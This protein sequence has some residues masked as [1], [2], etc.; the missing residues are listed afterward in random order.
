MLSRA[1]L[2]VAVA[3][4]A[5]AALVSACSSS[6]GTSSSSAPSS[7]SASAAASSAPSSSAGAS[8]GGS[9]TLASLPPTR[10]LAKAQ[11]AVGGAKSVHF[12]A[13]S[14]GQNGAG[15]YDLK[16]LANGNAAGTITFDGAQ[17]KVVK[18]G[19]VAYLS[20]HPEYLAALAP[21]QNLAG[22]WVELPATHQAVTNLL[23]VADLRTGLGGVLLPKGSVAFGPSKTVDGRPTVALVE[24]SSNG[25]G[26]VY[27]AA[28]GTPYPLLIESAP[29]SGSSS[30]ARF[31][32]WDKPVTVTAPAAAQVIDLRKAS[33]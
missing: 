21:G 30:S 18:I 20:G 7:A 10:V 6:S 3:V 27:V 19:D 25:G 23:A 13:N 22:K 26:T 14:T 4:A 28:A 16:L 5:A 17:L 32:E 2:V 9:S 24:T 1:R 33:S 12:T 31:S 29:G 15:G 11:A 8:A